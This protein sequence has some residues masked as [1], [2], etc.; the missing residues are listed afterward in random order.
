LHRHDVL[1]ARLK[2]RYGEFVDL[3]VDVTLE[4]FTFCCRCLKTFFTVVDARG[5]KS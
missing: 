2:R 3:S 1:A 5:K 4:R